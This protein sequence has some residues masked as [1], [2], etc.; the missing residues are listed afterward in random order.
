MLRAALIAP[1]FESVPPRLYGGTERVIHNLC[2]GLTDADVEVTLFASG[3]SCVEGRLVPIV[4]EALRLGCS[5][6]ADVSAL[7]T[8]ALAE[9]ARL[10]G[11][12]DVIHNHADFHMLPLSLTGATPLLTTLH[13]RLDERDPAAA[14]RAFGD[15]AYVAI[16]RSQR[17][18]LPAL[19]WLD[20]ILHGIDATSFEFRET[21]GTYLAFLGR[22]SPEKRPD[23]AIEIARLSG[24]PLKIAA[25]IEGKRD[26]E[27]FE[28]EI[29]PRIDG[30]FIEYVGEIS[31]AEKSDFLGS[32]LALA[33]PIDWPEPFG[34]VMI[35]SLA[36][37]TPVL[38]RPCGAVREIIED[39][40]TGFVDSDVRALAA[41]VPR[42]AALDRRRCRLEVERRFSLERMT[43]DYIHAYRRLIAKTPQSGIERDRHRRRQLHSVQRA[44]DRDR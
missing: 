27:Y 1:I 13:G 19:N 14:Y 33:F 20:T 34:L 7:W 30:R 21:P 36:C 9:V 38:A 2:R 26:T 37:G 44:A 29:R 8:R 5:R 11:E 23:W 25:K 28:A 22:I 10:S 12:F 18:Q 40:V 42:A 31:E 6:D 32:A 35:E 41:S 39:G 4:D 43:E 16:S 24:V 17:S 3:D 15:S